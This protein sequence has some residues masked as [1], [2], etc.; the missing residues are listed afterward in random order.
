MSTQRSAARPV[1]EDMEHAQRAQAVGEVRG[2][3]DRDAD[4]LTRLCD[5]SETMVSLETSPAT[6]TVTVTAERISVGAVP[7]LDI[8]LLY[9]MDRPD[10]DA[11]GLPLQAPD[12]GPIV[13]D[14]SLV[15][16]FS[17]PRA[18]SSTRTKIRTI[19]GPAAAKNTQQLPFTT[20]SAGAGPVPP[21]DQEHSAEL[22]PEEARVLPEP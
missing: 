16:Y 3:R 6:V 5:I 17:H 18:V 13:K 8:D 10:A 1:R 19:S 22:F 14:H 2:N 7:R 9:G 4:E 21:T 11:P 15:A 20:A 12:A